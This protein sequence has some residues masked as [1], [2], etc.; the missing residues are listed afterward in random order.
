MGVLPV[1]LVAATTEV[2]VDIDGEPHGG[3]CRWVRQ[4]PPPKLKNTSVVASGPFGGCP[5][6]SFFELRID[7][8]K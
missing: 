3:C 6:L 7:S 5:D 8:Y 2:E 1:C 4:R